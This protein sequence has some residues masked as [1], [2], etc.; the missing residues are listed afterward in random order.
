MARPDAPSRREEG[1]RT[2]TGRRALLIG[3]TGLAGGLVLPTAALAHAADRVAP[4]RLLP[5]ERTL[6]L[7]SLHT[8]E[9]LT[10]AYVRE[11]RY[12]QGALGEIDQI[13]RDW[14]SGD[15]R[16][17]DPRLLDLLYLLR[18]RV[19]GR[20]PFE[21]ISAYRSP[22]TNAQLAA[23]SGGVAK[24]SQH[25]LGKAIDV[26][27]PDAS[28]QSLHREALALRAGGVGLYSKSGFVHLDTG[29]V[30]RWGR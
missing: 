1:E 24:K 26:A 25:M 28:L 11:G 15:T 18:R 27:L 6:S 7:V 10:A 21:V 13:L 14:R 16:R 12:D 17:M 30:R 22:D 3:L 5:P 2:A 19:G 9:R 29:R 8:G 4:G 23:R 20:G